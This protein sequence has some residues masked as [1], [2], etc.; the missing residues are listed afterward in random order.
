MGAAGWLACW[1]PHV[2]TAAHG[3]AHQSFVG[4]LVEELEVP[5]VADFVSLGAVLHDNTS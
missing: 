5:R 1:M 2:N 4:L 3:R